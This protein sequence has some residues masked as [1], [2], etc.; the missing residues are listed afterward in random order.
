VLG[1]K[2]T[3]VILY[4]T[5]ENRIAAEAFTRAGVR[6]IAL[7]V[8]HIAQF[9]SLCARL[10]VALDASARARQVSDS[11]QHTLDAV[12]LAMRD[13]PAV[14]VV[15][16]LWESPLLAVGGGSY[17][18]EL[19]EIA[20]GRNIFHE[21][22]AP[23]PPVSIEEVARRAPA[24]V[25]AGTNSAK[26]IR[27]SKAWQSVA[28]VRSGHVAIVDPAVTGRPSVVLG[29]AAVAIARALHPERVGRLP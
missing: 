15:W 2:P 14:P 19:V 13:A 10:G 28:A 9:M 22:P 4:A 6:T 12:R 20:G 16:P 29:M 1:A 25:I 24:L 27:A 11:V 7:R 5:A 26:T 23:S 21:M 8:D 3:L 18:D 17:L